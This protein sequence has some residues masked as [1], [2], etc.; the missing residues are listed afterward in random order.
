MKPLNSKKNYKTLFGHTYFAILIKKED[1]FLLKQ[2]VKNL[3]EEEKK[4][5]LI[6]KITDTFNF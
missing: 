6:N 2:M 3:Q 5:S 4:F 1:V